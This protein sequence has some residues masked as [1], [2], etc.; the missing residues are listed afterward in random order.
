MGEVVRCVELL[1]TKASSGQVTATLELLLV[2]LILHWFW[3]FL[4]FCPSYKMQL[5]SQDAAV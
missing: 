2:R 5:R 3:S 4:P 1:G